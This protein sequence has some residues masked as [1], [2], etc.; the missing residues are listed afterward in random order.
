MCVLFFTVAVYIADKTYLLA[1]NIKVGQFAMSS[2]SIAEISFLNLLGHVLDVAKSALL[3]SH[4]SRDG[5]R[6]VLALG[7]CTSSLPSR[8]L[9]C[10]SLS[11]RGGG[12]LS[13]GDRSSSNGSSSRSSSRRS[14]SSALALSRRSG[15][16]GQR[17]DRSRSCSGRSST[18][19]GHGLRRHDRLR[20][21]LLGNRSWA[22]LLG[23]LRL[24]ASL[25][26]GF[27]GSNGRLNL[28]LGSLGSLNSIIAINGRI[29]PC[30]RSL[31][32]LLIDSSSVQLAGVLL[33]D[34]LD[35]LRLSDSRGSG[36]LLSSG[37]VGRLG[38]LLVVLLV[39]VSQDIIENK[40]ARRLL[41]EDEGL[42]KLLGLGALVGGLANNLDNNVLK[43]GLGVDVGDADLA[44]LEIK[45][46]DALLDSLSSNTMVRFATG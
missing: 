35:R 25:L 28:D 41:C 43:R 2:Q 44:V 12:G 4:V 9:L 40:V 37:S 18:G 14:R 39:N 21:L 19:P 8:C 45:G 24:R 32:E 3:L 5:L 7:V 23:L 16:L 30:R 33:D 36:L 29:L 13:S 34:L 31:L 26:G 20:R 10:R 27:R 1:V 11:S 46:L 38:R 6:A 15:S 17:H 42:D 22:G